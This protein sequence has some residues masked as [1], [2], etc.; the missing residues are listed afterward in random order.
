MSPEFTYI[1]FYKKNRV[2]ANRFCDVYSIALTIRFL[3]PP[4]SKQ[5]RQRKRTGNEI[6]FW[7][8]NLSHFTDNFW[9]ESHY[10]QLTILSRYLLRVQ[11]AQI[12]SHEILFLPQSFSITKK[13]LDIFRNSVRTGDT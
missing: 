7:Q 12:N 1:F 10:F 8:I 9:H 6:D 3:F 5:I 13:A 11:G 2:G 4:A